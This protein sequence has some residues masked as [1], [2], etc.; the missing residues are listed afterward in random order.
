MKDEREIK[1]R[2]I[3]VQ[4]GKDIKETKGHKGEK[5]K[6]KGNEQR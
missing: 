3:V 2:Q 4:I 6:D 1:K 5:D